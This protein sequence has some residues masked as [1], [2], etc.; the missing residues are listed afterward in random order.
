MKAIE[1]YKTQIGKLR[2]SE[3]GLGSKAVNEA[4]AAK[5]PAAGDASGV[6]RRK[7]IRE[8][9]RGLT[10]ST[11]IIGRGVFYARTIG[12]SR[13]GGNDLLFERE[14]LFTHSAPPLGRR[15]AL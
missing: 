12:H 5:L 14:G 9:G 15:M 8:A 1:D 3:H 2:N 4:Y 10:F 13:E 11:R 6:G 7:S